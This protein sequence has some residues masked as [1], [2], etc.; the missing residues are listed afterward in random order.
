MPGPGH[1]RVPQYP[2]G[3]QDHPHFPGKK[4]ETYCS[5]IT[6]QRWCYGLNLCPSKLEHR[7][8]SHTCEPVEKEAVR[9]RA[10]AGYKETADRKNLLYCVASAFPSHHGWA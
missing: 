5:E 3:Q 8:S 4:I 1:I 7:M 6:L 10:H 9:A 2:R